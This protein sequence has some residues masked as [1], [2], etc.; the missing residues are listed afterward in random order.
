M[1]LK[2]A[3]STCPNDTFIFDALVNGRISKRSELSFDILLADIQELNEIAIK[4]EADI[5]KISFAIYP[6]VSRNYQL[7]TSGAALGK[8]VG[9]LLISKRKIYPDEIKYTRIAIPGENTTANLLFTLAYPDAMQKQTYLFSTIEEVVLANEADVGVIIHEN[10]F[11]YQKKGL[12]KIMDLGEFW[13]KLSG[14]PIPL[15]GIAIKRYLPETVKKEINTLISHSVKFAMDNPSKSIN[16]VQS[17][18]QT[19]DVEV[20]QQHIK[21]YVN[22]FTQDLKEIGQLA[23]NELFSRAMAS[24][25]Y[26]SIDIQNPI[27]IE[28]SKLE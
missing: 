3:F 10:R 19:M 28:H 23:I 25:F 8:G 7:L 5:V 6:L 27:F 24:G 13:V 16:Y 11:T 21:L 4:A 22:N 17:H 15:G 20:M 18:A 2:L 1:K 14:L 26:K 9:P 12:K